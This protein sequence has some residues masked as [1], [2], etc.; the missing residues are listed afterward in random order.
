MSPPVPVRLLVVDDH[1]A[2]RET[3]RH[4][5][6]ARNAEIFEA[7]SGEEAVASYDRSHPDWVIMDMRMPGMGGCDATKSIRKAHPESRIIMIS[8]WSEPELRER[9]LVA[10]AEVFLNKEELSR[11][12]GIIFGVPKED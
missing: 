12:P 9:A 4:L 11:L 7:S 6:D 8:Q 1:A 2:F 10:G 3:V 5:F